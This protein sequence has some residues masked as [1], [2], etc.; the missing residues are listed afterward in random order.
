MIGILYGQ[1]MARLPV[2]GK[3]TFVIAAI[4]GAAYGGIAA[5][6]FR[7]GHGRSTAVG[8]LFATIA[9]FVGHY[10]AWVSW[11][12]VILS[13]NGAEGPSMLD[14]LFDPASMFAT[15]GRISEVGVWSV[16]GSAPSA[17]RN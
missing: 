11:I 3:I 16:S 2:V 8:G 5:M 17:I 1:L 6:L 15:I 14:I 4:A 10:M 7:A 13:R 9:S 12:S